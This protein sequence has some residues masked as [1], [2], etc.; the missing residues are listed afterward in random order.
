MNEVLRPPCPLFSVVEKVLLA[1]CQ[2]IWQAFLAAPLSTRNTCS[3]QP[4]GVLTVYRK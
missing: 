2:D 4:H 1:V 3:D